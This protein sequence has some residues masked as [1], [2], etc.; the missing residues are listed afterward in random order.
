MST[1]RN[2]TWVICEMDQE[3]KTD[4]EKQINNAIEAADTEKEISAFMKNFFDKKYSPNW[5]CVV[6]KHFASFVTYTS[7]HYIFF[8]IG[9][10][11]ILLYKL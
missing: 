11:A 9:Q 3:M 7:K 5:H 10:M 6:G 8:Y 1:E 2:V 4:V